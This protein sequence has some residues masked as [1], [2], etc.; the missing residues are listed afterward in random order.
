MEQNRRII[1]TPALPYANGPVHIGHIFEHLIC[2]FFAR[3]QK[4]RG[5]ESLLICGDD[6]HGT[7]IMLKASAKGISPQELIKQV[8]SDHLSD[9]QSMGVSYDNYSSTDTQSNQELCEYFY[10]TLKKQ[11]FTA[12]KA[13]EQYYCLHDKMFLP[14]RYITGTCPKCLSE[15]QHGDNC[16]K[17]GASYQPGEMPQVKCS[18]CKNAPEKRSSEH[19]FIKLEGFRDFLEN[20]LKTG[21]TPQIKNKMAEWLSGDLKD[22]DISRDEPYFGF[23]IPDMPGKYFYVW[24]DAP[25]GYIAST[26]EWCA[27]NGRDLKEFWGKNENT[28]IYHVVGK[29]IAYFHCLFWPAVLS[30]SQFKTPT[31]VIVHGYLNQGGEKMSKSRG[32]GFGPKDY[33]KHFD[34]TYLRYYLAC[35]YNG[36]VDDVDFTAE[37]FVARV[38]SDL[39]GKI[40]NIAS[41]GATMLAKHFENRLGTLDAEG[42]A[43]LNYGVSLGDE[44]ATHF[45][46]FEFAKGMLLIR[47]IADLANKY[48]DDYTPWKLVKTDPDKAHIVLTTIV[49]AF[50]II[51]IYLKPIIPTYTEK[52]ESLLNEPKPYTW[53]DS[54]TPIEN[55]NLNTY[56]H[57]LGRIEAKELDAMITTNIE[58]KK[59]ALEPKKQ[60]KND[61]PETK[62]AT[63]TIDDFTK[64][65]L[66]VG[67]IIEAAD[68]PGADKL[69]QLKIDIGTEVRQVF[70][71][72]KSS[73][74]PA[75]V[76]GKLVVLVANLAPRKMKFGNS[77]GM[78]LASGEG[79]E[80]KLAS[81]SDGAKVGD[82]IS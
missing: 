2:D 17:C 43:H 36:G 35:K 79:T 8:Y 57:L 47:N 58:S 7:P 32:I 41:R 67:K 44:I 56:S 61:K 5:H 19:L 76:L 73:Y 26:K 71:G 29:D 69:L 50:R 25:M 22:W 23:A 20:W 51:A 3:F 21:T 28:E 18:L 13:V 80:I 37:D 42:H 1:V 72:I 45:D 70:S 65:D 16:E 66:R 6:T 63:I 11:G 24:L 14:D 60:N 46:N 48:F 27:K 9:F 30:A 15:D 54:K 64:I 4:M 77:E 38:N 55:K 52:V 74:Q 82:K 49:N 53:N 75:D 59:I 39:I 62:S 33:V 31:K 10:N 12:I 68:V 78:I 81:V 40:T 34:P